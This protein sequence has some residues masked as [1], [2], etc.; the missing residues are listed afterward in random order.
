MIIDVETAVR[1]LVYVA[2]GQHPSKRVTVGLIVAVLARKF[3][4]IAE[5]EIR[6][7]VTRTVVEEGG[8]VDLLDPAAGETADLV[9]AMQLT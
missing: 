6:K 8:T 2:M 9:P 3:S 7:L 5:E 4:A 1:T